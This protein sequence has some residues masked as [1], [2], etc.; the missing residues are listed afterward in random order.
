MHLLIYNFILDLF[1]LRFNLLVDK[2]ISVQFLLDFL[3]EALA[4]LLL[5]RIILLQIIIE[6]NT[7]L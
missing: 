5:L 6:A 1:Y 3:Y 2:F 7:K 4:D